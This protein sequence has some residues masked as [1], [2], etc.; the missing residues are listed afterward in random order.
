MT[1]IFIVKQVKVKEKEQEKLTQ[2]K[3]KTRSAISFAFETRHIIQTNKR[4][5]VA[6]SSWRKQK[7]HEWVGYGN[8]WVGYGNEEN[9]KMLFVILCSEFVIISRS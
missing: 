3:S 9:Q 6:L 8:E 4:D 5:K 7:T 2:R 1:R